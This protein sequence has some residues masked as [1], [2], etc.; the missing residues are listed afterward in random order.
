MTESDFTQIR[1]LETI[2][3]QAEKIAVKL[4]WGLM[5]MREPGKTS[6][7]C[8]YAQGKLVGYMP[9]DGFG[10]QFEITAIV[11]PNYRRQG[12]FKQLFAAAKEEAIRRNAARL[13][14]VNYRNSVSGN[15]LV[16]AL[17]LPYHNSEYH[18][19][20]DRTMLSALPASQ[21][22]LLDVTAAN[23]ADLSQSLAATFGAGRWNS[24]AELLADLA[25][26]DGKYF[27]ATV[28]GT[29]I[30]QIG[31][32]TDDN[33]V[34]VRAVGIVPQWRGRGYGRQLLSALVQKMLAEGF[35][36]FALDVETA[37]R[38]ALSLYQSCGFQ[39]SNVYDYYIVPF[40]A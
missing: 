25:R 26:E 5:K 12:I 21:V 2:C 6:D 15:A 35:S 11:H 23:V 10:D 18:M 17:G 16:A 19:E 4:N 13:L 14:L 29:L 1:E 32:V 34:Y 24:E 8:H 27:L 3:N 33:E 38:N 36:R 39:E 31:V 22:N 28:D 37:N 7:F 40:A 30:G 9:V 20:T